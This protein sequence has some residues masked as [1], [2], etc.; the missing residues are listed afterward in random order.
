MKIG[1]QNTLSVS[2]DSKTARAKAL[3]EF[4]AMQAAMQAQSTAQPLKSVQPTA[5]TASP[6]LVSPTARALSGSP[7]DVFS[8]AGVIT[9]T[10]PTTA[11]VT[12]EGADTHFRNTL[13]MYKLDENGTFK[14][15]QAVFPNATSVESGGWM[16]SGQ[17]SAEIKLEA[18]DRVGFALLPN[19]FSN[20]QSRE[21]LMRDDGKLGLVD[22][23]GQ[24][25]N[26][27]KDS[28][29]K[30]QLVHIDD[31]GKMLPI[32]GEYGNKLLHST[33]NA[34]EGVQTN[35]G[36]KDYAD[37]LL[38][39]ERG[40]LLM[41]FDDKLDGDGKSRN[42][43]LASIDLGK[44]N[45]AALAQA[46]VDDKPTSFREIA[47][48]DRKASIEEIVETAR[49]FDADGDGRLNEK[50]WAK[51]A[52]LLNLTA[53]DHKHF[54]GLRGRGDIDSLPYL[55]KKGDANGDGAIGETELLE[56]RRRLNG[57]NPNVIQSF[58]EAAGADMKL[59]YN[60]LIATVESFDKNGD[61]FDQEEWDRFAS[62]LGMRPEDRNLFLD[63]H[64]KFD[65]SKFKTV[66]EVADINGDGQLDP[67]EVVEMRRLVLEYF[68]A[69]DAAAE[70]PSAEDDQM[71]IQPYP[72]PV[73]PKPLM[74]GHQGHA[75]GSWL[76]DHIAGLD[77]GRTEFWGND[78]QS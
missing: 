57:N 40:K 8:R 74:Q 53:D 42:S 13:I 28:P 37:Q 39:A 22:W 24:P 62:I 16:K 34:A 67:E 71:T 38:D 6:P 4:M 72:F 78:K 17:S 29:E 15:A 23:R 18:G 41:G 26:M 64:G 33:G 14:G 49:M 36:G 50:E 5:A 70:E 3:Q 7:A 19:G 60:E 11:K 21:L 32:S 30:V 12:F 20:K 51:F 73:A 47:G 27:L 54:V 58:R 45:A 63:A 56:L 77:K 65:L 59:D 48:A 10:E 66:F 46:P 75:L 9:V 76:P 25:A 68:A 31:A 61:G 44:T 35:Y 69:E 2:L 1:T 52:P 43:M 55:I